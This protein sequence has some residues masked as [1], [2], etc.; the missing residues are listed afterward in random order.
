VVNFASPYHALLGRPCY[1]KFMAVP[2]YGCL[3][4]KMPRPWV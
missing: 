3:K 4:L 2:Y 1:A